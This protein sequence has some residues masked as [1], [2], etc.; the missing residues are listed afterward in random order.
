M[1]FVAASPGRAE[2]TMELLADYEIFAVPVP[3]SLT[4]TETEVSF[5]LRDTDP[6]RAAV[7]EAAER[8][9]EGARQRHRPH[10]SR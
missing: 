5:V 7:R 4:A 1:L 9:A 10:A 6:V 8:Q 2:R 3:S